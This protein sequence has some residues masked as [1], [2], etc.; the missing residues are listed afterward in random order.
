MKFCILIA[1]LLWGS[2][3]LSFAQE[4]L[5]ES[6]EKSVEKSVEETLEKEQQDQMIAEVD[7]AIDHQ[8][9]DQQE[10]GSEGGLSN[11]SSFVA[12]RSSVY[13]FAPVNNEKYQP[14]LG[15]GLGYRYLGHLNKVGLEKS[16]YRQF[17]AGLY[18]GRFTGRYYGADKDGFIAGLQHYSLEI[19]VYLNGR[20]KAFSSGPI[21]KLGTHYN[22]MSATGDARQIE[23]D[24][25]KVIARGENKW[26]PLLGAAYFW[27]GPYINLTVG[28]EYFVLGK[29]KSFVPLTVSLGVA[30]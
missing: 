10:Q 5:E 25:Q 9:F 6:F 19:N 24:G 29:L 12:E 14:R 17:S 13:E 7:S 23:V 20:K 1:I 8:E 22:R 16:I 21:L 26:G 15:L 27:Q 4:V 3:N 2:V 11:N 28:S 30:F 18:Y